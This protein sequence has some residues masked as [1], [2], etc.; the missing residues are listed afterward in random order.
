[1]KKSHDINSRLRTRIRS[2]LSQCQ[3][4]IEALNNELHV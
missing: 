1:M 4:K 2:D 3:D